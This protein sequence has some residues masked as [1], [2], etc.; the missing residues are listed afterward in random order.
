[1]AESAIPDGLDLQIADGIALLT[2]NR[3]ERL[4]A[5][6]REHL[7]G[8]GELCRRVA[9]DPEVRVVVITGAGRGFSS[10]ADLG[11]RS[12]PAATNDAGVPVRVIGSR[13][14]F[15]TP[16]VRLNKPTIAAVNGIAVGA[17]L[18]IALAS[19][20][21]LCA[22]S[23][24]F[25]ANFAD[26]GLAPTDAV[27]YL[28][29]RLIGLSA[30]LEMLYTRRRVTAAE[31]LELH[32]VNKIYPDHQLL[33]QAMTLAR[34]IASAPPVAIQSAKIAVTRMLDRNYEDSLILQEHS[35]L[36]NLIYGQ[37]DVAEAAQAR[38]E[39]RS[40]EFSDHFPDPTP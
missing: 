33:E 13:L 30:A 40:G 25:L 19:D 39:K 37:H 17:G 12:T 3:P 18:G 26:L 38:S 14:D 22:E 9:G 35:H 1:M 24:E 20:I 7:I 23:G 34:D 29:P 6:A 31:A 15:M 28:L 5:L 4:N 36:E 16:L 32:L 10:G 2:L 21:R 8:F 27:A 11:T